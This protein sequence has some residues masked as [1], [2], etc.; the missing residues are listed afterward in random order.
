MNDSSDK[1]KKAA[2]AKGTRLGISA[3]LARQM[4]KIQKSASSFSRLYERQISA[5]SKLSQEL[6]S[7]SLSSKL[8]QELL[9]SSLSSKL[10]QELFSSSLSS[11]LSQE[12]FSSSLSSKLSQELLSSS[13]SS[14]L[15]QELLSSSLPSKL[16]QKLISS[17]LSSKLSQ[18]LTAS[19]W[20]LPQTFSDNLFAHSSAL[21]DMIQ[22]F[23]GRG[24]TSAM[25]HQAIKIT[26]D[27][28]IDSVEDDELSEQFRSAHD[29]IQ[30]MANEF[31]GL[32]SL[33]DKSRQILLWVL[34]TIIMPL[35]V[36]SFLITVQNHMNDKATTL[37]S[38]KTH[39]QVRAL[40]RCYNG[41]EKMALS[42]CRVV[43]GDG[44]RMRGTPNLKGSVIA[45]LPVG[46]IVTVLDSSKRAWLLIEADVDGKTVEGWIAR[47]YTT[48]FR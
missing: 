20:E 18:E 37:E 13:L 38:A 29:E 10:S 23:Y 36:G 41:E 19:T 8:S 31:L 45:S 46:K 32:E 33:S 7:S 42:S 30:E 12:L 27:I 16:S 9:S 44:L 48:P 21:N 17:S 43:L 39:R 34:N 4:E 5:T 47:R 24:L 14:K 40:A 6:L 22:R 2:T 1:S 25:L 28:S 3:D 15:S 11:K 26:E 35:I